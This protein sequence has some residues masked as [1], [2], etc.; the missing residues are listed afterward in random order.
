MIMTNTELENR[1]RD[2]YKGLAPDLLDKILTDCEK[3]D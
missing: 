3:R 2:A 1:V